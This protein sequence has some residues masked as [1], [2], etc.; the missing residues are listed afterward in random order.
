MQKFVHLHTHTEYSLLDG[1][2]RIKDLIRRTKE[3]G[4][5]S[6][7][8]TD[9]GVMYGAVDF[10]KEAFENGIK[11]IL[12]CEVYTSKRS[13]FDKE[14]GL[15]SEPGHLVLL[16]KNNSG[17][18]NL[19]KVVSIGFTEGFYYKPR[20]DME[21]LE[22]YSQGLI[23]LS[24]CLSG[25]IPRALLSNNYEK[26]KR[27]ALKYK[28]ILEEDSFYLELQSNGIEEQN[29]VNSQLIKLSREI[30]VPLIATN[31]A[32]YLRKQDAKAH[33]ILLCIQTGKNINDEDRMSFSSDDFYVKSPEE[34]MEIFGNIPEA[35][36]NTVKVADM[37]NVSLE[38]GKLHL[39]HFDIPEGE[40]SY[41]YLRKLCYDGLKKLYKDQCKD[42]NKI[43]RLEYEL[44]VIKQ[45][46]YVDYFLIVGD[47]IRYAKD[48]DIVVGPGR[49]SA[50][51]SL[52]SYSLGIT[53][54]DPIK[55]N[56][57]FERFLNPERVS[58]PDIDID[59]CY[60]RRQE[61]IDYVVR[62]YGEDR[63]AQII[64][65]GTMAARAVIRDVGRALDIPYGDVDK[66]AKMIPFQIGMNIDKALE[67]NAELK[68]FYNNDEGAKE[69]ID[70]ARL[71]EG[72]PR[73]ASTHAA[74]V[75]IS[76]EPVTEYVPLQKNDDSITTQFT[77]GL[78]EE[79]GLLKMDF[80]GLRT[81][82][83]IRDAV[84]LVY[85]NYDKKVDIDTLDMSDSDVYKLIGE[86]RTTGV[87][88]L[89]SAGMTQ[90]MKE[91][92]PTS[93][94]DIIAGISLYRPGPMDQIPRYI[95]NKKNNEK[96]KYHH[97]LL[98][99]ILNVTYGCMVYQEQV[100]QI[101]RDLAGYSMGRSDLVRRAMAKKKVSVMEEERKNFIYGATDDEGKVIVKGAVSNG[102][103]E[104]TANKIF[105]EMMDF[106]SYA[107]N[108]SHAAAYAVIAFQTAWLKCYYP[109][110]FMAA[111][112][113]SFLGSSE[114]ISQYIYECKN[115]GIKILPPD[116]NE[117]NVKFTVTNGKIR[118]GLTAVK[119][120]G[121]NAVKAII[122]ERKKEGVYKDLVDFLERIEGKDVNKRCIESLIKSGAFDWTKVYR[123][124]LLAV[125]EKIMDGIIQ[126]KKKSIEGQ[127]SIFD[128][129][130]ENSDKSD[131]IQRISDN[132]DIYPDIKEYPTK[133]L[134]SMEK[135]MLGLYISGHPL[136][137]FEKEI[138]ER[139]TLLSSDLSIN[140]EGEDTD[141]P[142]GDYKKISDGQNVYVGGIITS[143]KTKTTKN[144]NLMAFVTLEDLFG[145]M[146]IIIFPSILERYSNL[147]NE[148]NIVLVKGRISIREEEQ[149]KIICEEVSALRK[150]NIKKLYLKI[151]NNIDDELMEST[152][153]FLKFFNG[154][155][156]VILYNEDEKERKV[157][158]RNSWVNLNETV[159]SELKERFGGE[160]V[161]LV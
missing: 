60:E 62:K 119:N 128:V 43:D 47:F 79:L 136:K 129:S 118:F 98:E 154:S 69:L 1:A 40:D 93:L 77:M 15:D 123:S 139:V 127:L 12:G 91:L 70:T 74:G 106:A 80:L 155:I 105:D 13:R 19:M 30:D 90:F 41:G 76:K 42:Q 8:I 152:I 57:I 38:F 82:T 133:M 142:L 84:D 17:Y 72:M 51:G 103:D 67:M 36:S 11:P 46:G 71:L 27:I 31:D 14:A 135:E 160:N 28:D 23:A 101:V 117:S 48:N 120:V 63:V 100:M 158:E 35:V 114:K 109:V 78:L 104:K 122:N 141:I 25:D 2:N 153:S 143:K 29:I 130:K 3:L 157:L 121:E 45:M 107:F 16:S 125:Y 83:V 95:K 159:I 85:E 68:N 110:E 58:M 156:P 52:V 88:Q 64:T 137:D 138:K 140:I 149:P 34:M 10:Y 39:P 108:K 32:H 97:P 66:V 50:A 86:G 145:I 49:G 65:F 73:H 18:K 151:N 9:H 132:K 81:L 146:E 26:A 126:R 148:E 5:D 102:V 4:M 6:I 37:C 96:I 75:V 150:K 87:F 92:K 61:V 116:I 55:Y 111:L 134:L 113:N 21:I 112:L 99:N 89:E 59:F 131:E 44:S 22:K 24:G 147:I 115:L 56:L 7:A 144:G 33:E 54:I 20:I 161:K 53:T 124:K 94:E